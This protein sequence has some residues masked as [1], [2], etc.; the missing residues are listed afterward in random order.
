MAG[1]DANK[2]ELRGVWWNVWYDARD[3]QGGA[4]A[5]AKRIAEIIMTHNVDWVC[6][7]EVFVY[8]KYGEM[9]NLDTLVKK[10]TGWE[11]YFIPDRQYEYR[12]QKTHEKYSYQQ[13]LAIY[14]KWPIV[15]HSTHVLGTIPRAKEKG[16]SQKHI[17]EVDLKTAKGIVTVANTHWTKMSIQFIKHRKEQMRNFK[18]HIAGR[19]PKYPYIIGGDFNTFQE[20][21]VIAQLSKMLD[22]R[23]GSLKNPT[24]R[25][26]GKKRSL[27]FSNIDY[28][29]VFKD[30]EMTLKTVRQLDRSPS[31]H[32]PMFVTAQLETPSPGV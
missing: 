10:A 18:K 19:A 28:I 30:G 21:P 14:S 11:G 29:G 2:N 15:R 25:H 26:Y 8:D 22:L 23:T 9:G 6:L 27:L 24:W 13:G 4:H 7:Q 3:R 31:D 16:T 20:H 17:F 32:T 12:P 1:A 5:I